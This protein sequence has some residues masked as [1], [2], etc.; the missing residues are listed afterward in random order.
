MKQP[1]GFVDHRN[2]SHVCCLRRSLYGLKQSPRAWFSRLSNY[3][4][5]IGFAA[6]RTDPSLFIY[7]HNN[8]TVYIL[9]Y[10]DDIIITGSSSTTVSNI[11]SLLHQEFKMKDLGDLSFFLGMEVSRNASGLSLSQKRYIHDLLIRTDMLHC[12]PLRTPMSSTCKLSLS[13]GEPMEDPSSWRSVVGAL[14]YLSLTRPDVSFA[15][16][17]VCQFM[18]A[19]T[20]VH[21][22][23]V[24]RIPRYLKG[25]IEVSLHFSAHSNHSLYSDSDADWGSCP[26]DRRS[27]GGFLVYLGN[28]LISWSSKKQRTAARSSTESEYRA[29]ADTA[30]E[31]QWLRSLLIELRFPTAEPP[32]LYCDNIGANY[33]T[34]NATFHGRTKHVEID[35]DFVRDLIQQ[36]RLQVSY[37]AAIDQLADILTKPLPATRFLLLRSKMNLRDAPGES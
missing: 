9:V 11:I 22:Q 13:D 32:R 7:H 17:K 14:Q 18:H 25:T 15:V 1:A 27:T 24:K 8:V 20:S 4:L 23:A 6:S 5:T 12:K 3:L 10:V 26:V 2:P 21:W 37:K 29:L 30:A 28:N 36:N 33:L 16:N 35:F 34:A 19:P 31:L